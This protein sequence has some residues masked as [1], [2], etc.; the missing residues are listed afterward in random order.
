M[1]A[2][3]FFM[4]QRDLSYTKNKDANSTYLWIAGSISVV[5]LS[6]LFGYSH[7]HFYDSYKSELQIID[8]LLQPSVNS[9]G[10]VIC[11]KP[12]QIST[13]ISNGHV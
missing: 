9:E 3:L 2:L 6:V 7:K 8:Q 4:Y 1:I 12:E 11:P 13:Q 10:K 5:G